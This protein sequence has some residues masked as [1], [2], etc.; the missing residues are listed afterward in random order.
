MINIWSFTKKCMQVTRK[1]IIFFIFPKIGNRTLQFNY[2]QIKFFAD[3]LFV[4]EWAINWKGIH[5]MHAWEQLTFEVHGQTD[6]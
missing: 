6:V 2:L 5:E 1:N 3:E 4:F